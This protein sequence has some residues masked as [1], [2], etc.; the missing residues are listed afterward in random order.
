M[1]PLRPIDTDA[2]QLLRRQGPQKLGPEMPVTAA[3]RLHQAGLGVLSPPPVQ[4]VTITQA[5]RAWRPQEA[6]SA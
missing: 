6:W 3:I 2:L 5:G 1:I 4:V